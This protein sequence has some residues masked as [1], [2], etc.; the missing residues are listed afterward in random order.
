LPPPAKKKTILPPVVLEIQSGFVMGARLSRTRR[1]V[2]R[3]AIRE[4]KPESL[5]AVSCLSNVSKP[6][7]LKEA[8]RDVQAALGNGKG[9]LG[10]L[11]PDPIVRVS[12]L[13]FETLPGNAKD[14]EALIK[15][16]MKPLLHFA[17]EEARLS[18]EVSHQEP[19]RVEVLVMAA[20]NPVLAEY[21][22]AVE[23]SGGEIKLVLPVTMAL[24]PLLN[25]NAE[26]GELLLHI[27]PG[28]L[29]AV[30]LGGGRVR[31]W[32]SQAV[33]WTSPDEC[34]KAVSEEAARA[35]AGAQDHLGLAVS[36]VLL[37]VRPPLTEE[38]TAEFGR[39]ISREVQ[40]LIGEVSGRS[41]L[42]ADETELLKYFG[43]PLVGL[44]AN[45]G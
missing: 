22:S 30:M 14:Q 19:S 41:G 44:L 7:Q 27:W 3:L 8:V 33:Q 34:L 12:I 2:N 32:R 43:A 13:E 35:L 23:A 42:S 25:E 5:G 45:A 6:E 15:W 28:G 9:P 17:T 4:F 31:L 38:W 36:R 18:F 16:K 1:R 37:C 29:T 20:R 40:V 24:L 26:E 11:V 21:E 39:A 10:L